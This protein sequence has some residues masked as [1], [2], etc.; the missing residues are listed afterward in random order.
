MLCIVAYL[1][2]ANEI[3]RFTSNG[4]STTISYQIH[5]WNDLRE[6]EQ[7]VYKGATYFKIG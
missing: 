2:H 5:S 3:C 4:T 6:W 7:T 1:S